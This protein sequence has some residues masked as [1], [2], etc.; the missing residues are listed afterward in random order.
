MQQKTPDK[1]VFGAGS[2]AGK[3]LLC[4]LMAGLLTA[5][6]RAVEPKTLGGVLT[7][8]VTDA[9]GVPQMGA[10]VLLYNR[11]EKLVGRVLTN[12]RGGFLFDS[13]V[14]DNYSL[15]VTLASFV[16][17]LKRN[18][19]IQPGM[20]SFLAINLTSVLSS[21]E[22]IYTAPGQRAFMSE[23]WKW[24]LRSSQST[25][26][27][28]RLLP[29][30]DIS[31][32]NRPRARRGDIFSGT[33]GVL[34]LSSGDA[35]ELSSAGSQTDLGTAF[36]LATS[37]YGSNQLSVSGN[38][39]Y[40]SHTGTST[41]GFSTS[42]TRG[43][44]GDGHSPEVNVTMRQ[45]FL[46]ARIGSSLAAGQS[47][48]IPALQTLT[49]TFVDHRQLTDTLEI[50]YGASME[51]VAFL[52]RLNYLSPFG[53]ARW[54]SDEDGAFEVAFSSGAPATQLL[55]SSA[56][57]RNELQQNLTALA[58]FPRVSLRNGQALVQRTENIEVGYRRKI[59]GR[60]VAVSAYRER[61]SNA[62]INASAGQGVFGGNDLLPDLASNTSVFNA[63]R[64]KR[65]GYE[66]SITQ[67]LGEDTAATV[68]YG[69]AGA[70][71]VGD[72]RMVTANSD[73]LRDKIDSAMRQAITVRMTGRAPRAGTRYA[74][75]YQFTD[76]GMLHPVHLS[77]TQRS[78][79]EPGLNLYLRQPIPRVGLLPGRLEATAELR[80]M[81]AQGY[82]SVAT[83]NGQ[84]LVLIQSPRAVRG[85]LSLIF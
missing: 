73:E 62:A 20:R 1:V 19:A 45:I 21:I 77:L 78:T 28:L 24:V 79:M 38:L 71:S 50:E 47:D 3:I 51:S 4:G 70:L 46:P 25:R 27:V 14:P 17:A 2:A 67:P 5:P 34:R 49:A 42:F 83:P 64:F 68:A 8:R 41:A 55:E 29:G 52:N 6:A 43:P 31:D 53:R 13:L 81:L 10:A 48:N 18:V 84:R 16:P 80:N 30:V 58:L 37:I 36:A 54:G 60:T 74:A 72:G 59:R 22:L 39:G 40:A 7:G 76:Y 26:P 35:G 56:P 23:D 65:M 85:G 44:A 33:K 61:V 32:P 12:E 11:Y 69:Y 63:G 75:S 57:N 15:R 82:L 9:A 66:A